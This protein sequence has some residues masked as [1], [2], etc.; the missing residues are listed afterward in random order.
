MG[1]RE[2][3]KALKRQEI[4][5][6]AIHLFDEKGFDNVTVAEIAK[7]AGIAPKTL[8]T[9]FKSKDDIMFHNETALLTSIR[10]LVQQQ[11]SVANLWPA[12][13]QF[14]ED[15]P[16]NEAT[17]AAL[18]ATRRLM[19][20][21][22]RTPELNGR[23]LEMW[24]TYEAGVQAALIEQRLTDSLTAQVLAHQMILVLE[25]VFNAELSDELW[26]ARVTRI[27]NA[28]SQVASLTNEVDMTI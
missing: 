15:L 27:F 2:R 14:A 17:Q 4:V 3:K 24:A 19:A 9:Y 7:Q 28:T 11:T 10:H 16:T 6:V 23:R 18:Q 12:F 25:I 8:F 13:H 21:V 22:N 26:Q 5:T 1:L 20:N